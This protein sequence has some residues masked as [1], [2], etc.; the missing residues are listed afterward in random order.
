ML[1][2]F[3][4]PPSFI[5]WSRDSIKSE[6]TGSAIIENIPIIDVT[7]EEDGYVPIFA[8]VKSFVIFDDKDDSFALLWQNIYDGLP[9]AFT[10]RQ[11]G[12]RKIS[13]IFFLSLLPRKITD[14]L[15][16]ARR[17]LPPPFVISTSMICLA[18]SKLN[19]VIPR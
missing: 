5:S 3:N 4:Q 8:L 11:I 13:N 15:D 1:I 18:L 7:V 19:F 14:G 9:I 12:K 17:S 10:F 2:Q 6:F 16:T